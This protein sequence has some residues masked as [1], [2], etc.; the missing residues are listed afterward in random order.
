MDALLAERDIDLHGGRVTALMQARVLGYV[1]NPLTLYW[2]HDSEGVVRHVHPG[3][4]FAK[5]SP[6]REARRDYAEM[7]STIEKLLGER[8]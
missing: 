2:C 7:R 5:D 3:G 4:V 1:F 8:P 6:D